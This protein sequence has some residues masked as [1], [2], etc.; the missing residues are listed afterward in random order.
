MVEDRDGPLSRWSRLKRESREADERKHG[1]GEPEAQAGDETSAAAATGEQAA[2][3][4]S[5]LPD[6]DSLTKDSDYTVFLREG[7]PE[8]LRA[9]ALRKLWRSDP[10]L[11]N[12]DGLNNYDEDFR[13]PFLEAGKQVVRTL[14]RIGRGWTDEA[15]AE[16]ADAEGRRA[17]ASEE[18]PAMPTEAETRDEPG[19]AE[20]P[21]E[22]ASAPTAAAAPEPRPARR[23]GRAR[24]R[25]WG[26]G[27]PDGGTAGAA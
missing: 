13:K 9:K 4:P 23:K 11:A 17:V 22:E 25:R 12:L 15:G 19:E 10:L 5:E 6:I 20:A 14:Y 8:Q 2:V 26:G 1:A 18:R 16:D 27:S 7:V 21:E 3:D 24:T